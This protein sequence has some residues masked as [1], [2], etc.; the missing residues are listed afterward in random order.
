MSFLVSVFVNSPGQR[1]SGKCRVEKLGKRDLTGTGEDYC[2]QLG[3]FRHSA[4]WRLCRARHKRHSFAV[5]LLRQGVSMK[6]I[7]DTLGHRDIESTLTYLRL[8][9]E[10]LRM[11][12]L[13]LPISG[14][15]LLQPSACVAYQPRPRAASFSRRL[16][17]RFRSKLSGALQRFLRHKRTLG[18]AYRCEAA[19]LRR[20]DDFLHRRYPEA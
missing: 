17:R 9:L 2:A 15:G 7:G 1:T 12:A 14:Q 16:S 10:D 19:M 18:C 5:H 3:I 20:W 4:F 6:T 11:V 13:P 8:D